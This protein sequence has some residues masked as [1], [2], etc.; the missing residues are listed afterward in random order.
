M[1]MK[2]ALGSTGRG[3]KVAGVLVL[4]V[5]GFVGCNGRYKGESLD[6]VIPR[7]LVSQV[8]CGSSGPTPPAAS[9][10]SSIETYTSDRWGFEFA[11]PTPQYS[12]LDDQ[13]Q[14]REGAATRGHAFALLLVNGGV[15]DNTR[16]LSG[17]TVFVD[18]GKYLTTPVEG[19]PRRDLPLMAA[20]V[21]SAKYT[22]AGFKVIR[23][24]RVTVAGEPGFNVEF[25]GQVDG[26]RRAFDMT[27]VV[28]RKALYTIVYSSPM[29]GD[30]ASRRATRDAFVESFRFTN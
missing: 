3:L 10:E 21:V 19:V 9:T 30:A 18:K 24:R 2:N 7:M 4:V 5:L 13:A 29:T 8:G 12:V 15:A 11:Y 26:N 23:H 22:K 27:W 17:L 6:V 28:T 14:M 16:D 20:M 1:W 25:F